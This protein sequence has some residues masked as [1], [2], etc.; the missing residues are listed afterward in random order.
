MDIAHFFKPHATA[1]KH[2]TGL[3]KSIYTD[4]FP[5]LDDIDIAIFGVNEYRNSISKSGALHYTHIINE[6]LPLH[7]VGFQPRI[8]DLGYIEHGFTIEDSYFA[9]SAVL[10]VLLKKNITPIIIGGSHDLSLAQFKGYQNLEQTINMVC[11]DAHIDLNPEETTLNASNFIGAIVLHEP[12]FLFNYSHI[13]FQSYFTPQALLDT[14]DKMFFDYYRLGYFKKA[15]ERTEPLIR[16]ADMLSVDC[17][18]IRCADFKAQEQASPNGFSAEEMCQMM[19]YA[20]MN[21]RMSSVGLYG[22]LNSKDS[23]GMSAALLAQMI[24]CFI[25]GF[26]ARKHDFPSRSSDDYLRFHVL[27]EET[28]QEIHFYKSKK[29]NRWWM[30]VPYPSTPNTKFERHTL[31]PCSYEDYEACTH[32]E[33]PDRWWQTYQKLM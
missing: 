30:E 16:Q 13:G 3:I 31:I 32:N 5:D 7:A 4:D 10:D 24:W 19:R 26:Y 29:T 2:S 28:Q 1:L 17:S 9:L 12:N 25:E 27:I 15:I 20:G 14:M 6:I 21:D 33:V 22:Y 11:I 8:A 23:D 18:A